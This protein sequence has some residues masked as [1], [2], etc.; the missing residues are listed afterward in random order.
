MTNIDP[1]L[2]GKPGWIFLHSITLGYPI[3]PT[4]E[5]K[6]NYKLFFNSIGNILPCSTCRNNYL[7]S[8][9]KYKL[10]DEVLIT[11]DTLVNWLINI[12]LND[13]NIHNKNISV[14]TILNEIGINNLNQK[15]NNAVNSSIS[16]T[17]N[18][19]SGCN[20]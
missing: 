18:K 13:Q 5:E 12:R 7:N 14:K 8:L 4:E 20:C 1:K 16:T 15:S 19:K 17:Y 2:W 11:R 9:N 6:N 10:T 3:N